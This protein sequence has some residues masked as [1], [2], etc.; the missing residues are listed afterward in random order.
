[1]Y[2]SIFAI[3][4]AFAYSTSVWAWPNWVTQLPQDS[5][6]LVGVGVGDSRIAARQA[7]I[8]EIVTQLSIDYRVEQTQMLTKRLGKADS[9][10]K[11]VSLLKSLPFTLEG[12]EELK[13]FQQDADFAL[14][15]GIKKNQLIKSLQTDLAILHHITQPDGDAERQFIWALQQS[16]TFLLLNKKLRVLTLLAGEQPK[17]KQRLEHLL[18]I[19]NKALQAVSCDVIGNSNYSLIKSALNNALPHSGKTRLWMRPNLKWKFATKGKQTLAKARLTLKLMR[20]QSPFSVLIQHD[21]EAQA[22]GSSREAAKAKAI[23]K[24]LGQLSAPASVWLFDT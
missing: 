3:L 15:L 5:E 17:I 19:Q 16:E 13:F 7:A 1:M 18:D 12:I 6:Y 20:S 23:K 21:I 4:L 14:L 9:Q 2:K 24:L 11:Q 22:K 8:A 10:F